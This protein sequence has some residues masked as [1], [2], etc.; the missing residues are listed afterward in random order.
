MKISYTLISRK[1]VFRKIGYKKT[2]DL[3]LLICPIENVINQEHI[4]AY[5]YTFDRDIQNEGYK[6]ILRFDRTDCFL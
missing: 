5:H 6:Y 4:D 2:W 3:N 1:Q